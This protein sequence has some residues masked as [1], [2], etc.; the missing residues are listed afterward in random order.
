VHQAVLISYVERSE[1]DILSSVAG[2]KKRV[3]E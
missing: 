1:F 3:D 2:L